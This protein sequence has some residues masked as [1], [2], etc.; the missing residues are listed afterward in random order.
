V[1]L[2][3]QVGRGAPFLAAAAVVV[4]GAEP[5]LAH[6]GDKI[7]GTSARP[8]DFVE[9]ALSQ[10]GPRALLVVTNDSTAAGLLYAQGV[11]GERPDVLV[12]VRQ[13]AWDTQE[14]AR[15]FA[16]AGGGPQSP[17]GFARFAEQ[18][19]DVRIASAGVELEALV[20]DAVARGQDVL[21]EPGNDFPTPAGLMVTP[22]VPL[23]RLGAEADTNAASA[24]SDQPDVAAAARA[25]VA[26][27][28]A[29]HEPPALDL[30]TYELTA[31]ARQS[32][33]QGEPAY[34]WRLL[35]A[36]QEVAPDEPGTLLDMAVLVA[37]T[38]DYT[39]AAAL[40]D[41]SIALDPGDVDAHI[42]AA[43]YRL[44]LDDD[45]TA[46]A[47]VDV[48]L[49]IDP[50][51]ADALALEGTLEARR[52]DFASA[53]R[54]L[55]AALTIDPRQPDASANLARLGVDRSACRPDPGQP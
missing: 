12:V 22:G 50:A 23:F 36:A 6:L 54:D 5:V 34:A 19:E 17:T 29:P 10:A 47:H 39:S 7:H 48:A 14:L 32:A 11:G 28:D 13:H 21:F 30:L 41:Q 4:I 46:G 8:H 2:A 49:R 9:T 52:G 42:A 16:R 40:A 37:R 33:A 51:N 31:L 18:P 55:C 43:R 20:R 27:L 45:W 26:L 25:A 24:P 35:Q 44:D 15:A 3:Q 1:W 38:G 53:Q